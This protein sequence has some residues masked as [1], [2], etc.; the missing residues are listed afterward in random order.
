MRKTKA[1]LL[2]VIL[3][4]AL[5]LPAC[6]A[7]TDN[8]VDSS[9]TSNSELIG[10][11]KESIEEAESESLSDDI[12]IPPS[13]SE[14]FS[15]ESQMESNIS[16]DE[17]PDIPRLSETTFSIDNIAPYSGQPY[18]IVN[19]NI[20]YFTESDLTTQ[21]FEYYSDLDS[22]GRCGVAYASIGLDLMPTEERGNIGS[23]KPSGWQTVKY[24]GIVEGNYLYN[25][26]HLIGFQLSGENANVKNLITGTRYMNVQGMLPFE[27][28]VAD[29]VKETENHVL[30]R[31]TPIF[32]GDNLLASGVLMEAESVED[33]GDGILFNVFCYNV[34]P[35]IIIDYVTGDS[36]LDEAAQTSEPT[37]V[38][39]V[40]PTPVPTP[41]PTP[42]SVTETPIIQEPTQEPI[43][44]GTTYIIN[45]NTGKFHY[46]TCGSVKQ[47]KDK[48]KWEYSSTRDEVISMGYD[49]CKKCNP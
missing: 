5:L 17:Q 6:A 13:E 25:R 15:Q 19:D 22:L 41:E 48:N 31:V 14:E 32:E 40:T 36:H 47:M 29:Y 24:N 8:S 4:I 39:T 42:E 21:S 11:S 30:Y 28:M 43:P 7:S 10:E 26:C 38:P 33:V 44:Q 46:P 1:W 9:S 34:Q 18:A 23:V 27:N 35:D 20:P 49:P 3:S 37:P 45:T 16:E 12:S 2:S